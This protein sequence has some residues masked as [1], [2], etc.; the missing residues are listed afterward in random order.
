M[1]RWH[2]AAMPP[3]KKKISKFDKIAL[4]I[5]EGIAKIPVEGEKEA[6][7]LLH[8]IERKGKAPE[9]REAGPAKIRVESKTKKPSSSAK[10]MHAKN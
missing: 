1:A 6:V 4:E 5:A 3:R 10:N 9:R 7:R 8:E 2:D